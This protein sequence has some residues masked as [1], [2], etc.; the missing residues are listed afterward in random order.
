LVRKKEIEG[1][2]EKGGGKSAKEKSK[3]QIKS[4]TSAKKAYWAHV[5]DNAQKAPRKAPI[6]QR[7]QREKREISL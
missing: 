5:L 6:L 3:K 1:V 4:N 7:D 2:T